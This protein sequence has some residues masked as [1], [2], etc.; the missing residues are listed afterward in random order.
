MFSWSNASKTRRKWSAE[1]VEETAKYKP[2]CNDTRATQRGSWTYQPPSTWFLCSGKPA[3]NNFGFDV[4]CQTSIL[5]LAPGS[6]WSMFFNLQSLPCLS[7]RAWEVRTSK[8][9]LECR[10]RTWLLLILNRCKK[11]R[12][13]GTLLWEH[14]S[15]I[16][17][18]STTQATFNQI[19]RLGIFIQKFHLPQS[20]TDKS[21]T[22]A[23]GKIGSGNASGEHCEIPNV[24]HPKRHKR[25]ERTVAATNQSGS[26]RS[27]LNRN[28]LW[29]T[30]WFCSQNAWQM[31]WDVLRRLELISCRGCEAQEY[32]QCRTCTCWDY[33]PC[34]KRQKDRIW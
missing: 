34:K 29:S 9:N 22:S 19:C 26:S 17:W 23:S 30:F 21:N 18:S 27:P 33:E 25:R 4:G 7:K 28:H 6:F 3:T 11:L 5:D 24:S 8:L 32:D 31:P 2:S 14:F 20:C 15:R 10:I 12:G 16:L 13:F 1:I